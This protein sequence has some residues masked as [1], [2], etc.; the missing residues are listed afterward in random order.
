VRD[1]YAAAVRIAPDECY[2]GTA[3]SDISLV[4]IH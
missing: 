3:V 4:Q 2:A 1:S